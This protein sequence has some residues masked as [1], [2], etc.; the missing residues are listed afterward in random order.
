M[1]LPVAPR[2]WQPLLSTRWAGRPEALYAPVTDSTNLQLKRA[3]RQGAPHGT[4]ALCEAQTAGRGRMDRQ[5]HSPE[6][7]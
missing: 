7:K 5:W 4:V 2:L 6:V 3:A 1:I